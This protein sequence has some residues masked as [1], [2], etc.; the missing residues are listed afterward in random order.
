MNQLLFYLHYAFRNLWRSRR[1][2]AF[3]IF[4]VAAGVAT[5]VAL[6]SLGLAIADSLTSNIRASNHGDIRLE[7]G[8]NSGFFSFSDPETEQGFS[9]TNLEQ[10]DDW[11][12]ERGGRWSASTQSGNL[13]ITALDFQSVGRPQFITSYFIDPQTYPPTQDITALEPAG[14]PLGQLFQGGNEVVVS[15]NLASSQ[16]IAVGD[17]VRVSGTAEEFIVR[18]IVPTFAEAGLRNL[19]AAFFGFAYF[20][21]ALK[22]KLPVAAEPNTIS[23]LLSDGTSAETI[24][25]AARDLDRSLTT[26][27]FYEVQTVPELIEENQN[28][29]DVLSSFIVVLGL[30]ALLI[31]GVGIMN[32]MLVLMR[33]RTEEIATLKTFGLKGRQVAAMFMAEAVLL[34]VSG[35][36]LGGFFGTLLS[37][38]ANAYGQALIQQPLAWRVYPEAIGFGLVLG[39]VITLVFGIIPVLIAVKVRPATILRPNEMSVPRLG[40]LQSLLMILLVVVT[41]GVIAGQ[42]LRPAFAIAESSSLWLNPFF[43]GVI[44][45]A[46]TLLILGI[47]IGLLWLVV[48]LIGKLPSFGSVDLRL[49]LRNLSTNRT[50]TATTLLALSTGMFALS[51]ISFFGAGVR[52]IVQFSLNEQLGGNILVVGALPSFVANPLIDG[53]LDGQ[54]GVEYR[55]RYFSYFGEITLLNGEPLPEPENPFNFTVPT[56]E[57]GRRP[58]GF[59]E[60]FGNFNNYSATLTARE[61]TNPNASYRP[62]A[63]RDLTA[64]DRGRPV[65]LYR[66]KTLWSNLNVQVGST[67]TVMVNNREVELEVVGLLQAEGTGGFALS[68]FT[69]GDVIVPP[70]LLTSSFPIQLNVARVQPERMNDVLLALNTIPLVYSFDI[71]FIDSILS[72]FINQMSAIPILVGLLS[73]GAAAVIMANTVALSTLER[74]RQIGILKAV[75]LKGRRVLVVMLLENVIISLLGS[76][77]GIGLSALG[78]SIVSSLSI[79]LSQIIPPDSTP[80]ALLLIGAAIAIGVVATILS[81][82][83]ALGERVTSVLRYE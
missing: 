52:Q 19:G 53:T 24:R 45:V 8:G 75:G 6:R 21:N 81:A 51:S 62:V 47:L 38:G 11:V 4:S 34:G 35:S 56:D 70:G 72:R 83:P 17:T 25:E 23:V 55:T 41:I 33:R 36:L 64:E 74:R 29:A 80:V 46:V 67:L 28:I 76:L 39:V 43:I 20:D 82:R 59:D 49:A 73:L 26:S 78:I 66:P 32:T 68:G 63:G 44:S 77:L 16:G 57:D 71:T 48:W 15:E 7:G 14:V 22:E 61:T 13:Q 54:P 18:G 9:L 12:G 30:G 50:R 60:D 37:F 65:A 69:D 31:G 5:V 40:C 2:S 3:A 79:N 42:I 58:Q 27:F 1:W 10:I